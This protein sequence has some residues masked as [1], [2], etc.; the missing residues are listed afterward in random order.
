MVDTPQ[1]FERVGDLAR[2]RVAAKAGHTT[3]TIATNCVMA[4]ETTSFS[5]RDCNADSCAHWLA[6]GE[7]PASV[8]AAF[9]TIA[10]LR[11]SLDESEHA[12]NELAARRAQRA[13][14]QAR[15]RAD[16][17]AARAGGPYAQHVL[18]KLMAE[19]AEIDQFDAQRS[20]LEAERDA[21][22]TA[23]DAYIGSLDL[24]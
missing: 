16:V 19:D 3:F 21:R 18:D 17:A 24:R 4:F 9:A 2:W 7:V 23:L 12:L 20:G 10:A 1:P 22:A 6:D 11:R 13:A 8:H 15:L 14:D 5:L